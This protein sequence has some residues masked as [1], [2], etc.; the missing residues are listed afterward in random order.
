MPKTK[1]DCEHCGINL[2]EYDYCSECGE[3]ACDT[4]MERESDCVIAVRRRLE[5]ME[6]FLL[7]P[8]D[9]SMGERPLVS[10][11]PRRCSPAPCGRQA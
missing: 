5:E 11:E 4:C 6:A 9:I 8:D 2:D 10:G 7:Y 3:A 1:I